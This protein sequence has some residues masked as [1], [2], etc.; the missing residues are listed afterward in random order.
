MSASESKTNIHYLLFISIASALG[1]LLF[2]YDLLVISGAKQF[3]ELTYGLGSA[4]LQG[5][6]VSSCIVGCI[7]G[8]LVVGRISDRFGRVKPL[9]VSALLFLVSAIGS[10]YAPDFTQFALYRILGGIGMGMAS[11]LSPMYI[12]EIAPAHLRGRLVSLNQLT[13]VIGILLAQLVNYQIASYEP[14]PEIL[15]KQCALASDMLSQSKVMAEGVAGKYEFADQERTLVR[16]TEEGRTMV[17]AEAFAEAPGDQAGSASAVD[18]GRFIAATQRELSATWLGTTGWRVMFAAEGVPALLFLVLMLFVPESPRWLIWN[19]RKERAQQVLSKI[20]NGA[21]A[22]KSRQEIESAMGGQKG[23]LA[24]S[25]LFSPG[26][27]GI[28]FLGV[29]VAVFQQWCG[30]NVI[31]NYAPDIFR[32]A[33]FTVDGIL[34]NLVIIGLTNMLFTFVGMV[35]IDRLGRKRLLLI[36][37]AGL[38]LSHVA[39]GV[40]YATGITGWYVV[41]FALLAIAFFAA[42]LGPV[43]WVYLS[44]IFPNA[45]RGTAIGIAVLSLWVA[46][47]IL[48]F[49]FP[50]L[51]ASLGP[52]KTFWLYALICFGGLIFLKFRAPETRGKTLEEI[53]AE[54]LGR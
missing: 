32:D 25:K 15:Q 6:A 17:P 41:G 43:A 21:Y 4:A 1:G 39:I 37:S 13:I 5:W 38:G 48:S 46:N 36:G 2:G 45:V 7:I 30:I 3:Y 50:I 16:P 51:V 47:F 23:E 42:T 44:E 29:F 20:G 22:E 40:C 24:F 34:F 26:F 8:A 31:F 12:A 18:I 11:T 27:L 28:L 35:S 33:G 14:V 52:A 53:E 54:L 19:G 49:T 10:G 9:L